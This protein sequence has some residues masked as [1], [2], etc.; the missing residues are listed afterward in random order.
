MNFQNQKS[1]KVDVAC[2]TGH[3]SALAVNGNLEVQP[4]PFDLLPR[5]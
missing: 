4:L 5:F 2:Y 1:E 3:N